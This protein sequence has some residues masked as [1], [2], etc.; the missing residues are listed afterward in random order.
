MTRSDGMGAPARL[1][2]VTNRSIADAGSVTTFGTTVP[3][4]QK[5]AGVR[6]PP[7]HV[8]P[9]PSR[10]GP[11]RSAVRAERQPWA[12]VAREDD[13]RVAVEAGRL[14]RV[15]DPACAR[16]ELFDDV[17]VDAGGAVTLE[18]GGP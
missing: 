15:E 10:R 14:Q 7:S 8:V 1:P 9:F 11:R 16:V 17:A 13:E 4:N 2:A 6:T 5:I 12:V 3:G 18:R